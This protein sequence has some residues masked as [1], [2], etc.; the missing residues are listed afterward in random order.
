MYDITPFESLE[1]GERKSHDLTLEIQDQ[2]LAETRPERT[3]LNLARD[4]DR[5]GNGAN[6]FWG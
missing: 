3:F 4:C 1:S 5:M 2:G 6:S